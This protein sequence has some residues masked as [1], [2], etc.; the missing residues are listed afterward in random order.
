[1]GTEEIK[2]KLDEL[3]KNNELM[4]I[5]A[6]EK[7]V[8]KERFRIAEVVQQYGTANWIDQETYQMMMEDILRGEELND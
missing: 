4:I 1:V 2:S 5:V 7:G 3:L 8:F 6:E